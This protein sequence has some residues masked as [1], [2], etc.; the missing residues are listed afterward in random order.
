[1]FPL[2]VPLLFFFF[3]FSPFLPYLYERH[4]CTCHT[5]A[6]RPPCC[7]I[8]SSN[9]GRLLRRCHHYPLQQELPQHFPLLLS[10]ACFFSLFSAVEI[11]HGCALLALLLPT[12]QQPRPPQQRV[13]KVSFLFAIGLASEVSP[14][15]SRRKE[16]EMVKKRRKRRKLSVISIVFYNT[17][18]LPNQE[19]P[20]R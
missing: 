19:S 13:A 5:S 11:L 16:D 4:T 6:S 20:K 12:Q 7:S 9:R 14:G 2:I 8:G 1:M 17:P 15:R 10:W 3:S 18:G